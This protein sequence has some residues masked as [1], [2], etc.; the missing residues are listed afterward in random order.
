MD[1]MADC[2][3]DIRKRMVEIED[4]AKPRCPISGQKLL[5]VCLREATKCPPSCRYHDQWIGPE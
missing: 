4:E 1:R 5:S 2:F 3:E